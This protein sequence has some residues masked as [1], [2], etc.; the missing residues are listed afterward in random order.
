MHHVILFSKYSNACK[1]FNDTIINSNL[2][3]D[4]KLLCIDNKKIRDKIISP[5]NTI[6][7]KNVPCLLIINNDIIDKYEGQDSF[8]W[9]NDIILRN[10]KQKQIE[11]QKNLENQLIQLK[12]QQQQQQQQILQE[13]SKPLVNHEI[14]ESFDKPP[15]PSSINT[16]I[17]DI[18]DALENNDIDLSSYRGNGATN[19]VKKRGNELKRENLLSAAMEMQKLREIEDKNNN[20]NPNPNFRS[21]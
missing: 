19:G 21:M 4:F 5:N 13:S 17:D 6:D 2:G 12:Q 20:P 11:I 3:I 1:K 9:L 16:L 8:I 15:P 10:E 14:D 7:I 18:D